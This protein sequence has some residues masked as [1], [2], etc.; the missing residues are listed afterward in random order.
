VLRH[1]VMEGEWAPQDPCGEAF[2]MYAL[3]QRH[4]QP[5]AMAAQIWLDRDDLD[6]VL[7]VYGRAPLAGFVRS[8]RHK[9]Y[10]ATREQYRSNWA[11]P[12]SMRCPR[13][14]RGYA[15]LAAAVLMFELQA[16]WWHMSEAAELAGDFPDTRIIV[17]HAGLPATRDA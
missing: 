4:G 15:R 13:W 1:V 14:R 5:Q 8:V 7:T 6:D 12:G 2:W 16:P 9:P 3:A 11:E 17:N 10:C